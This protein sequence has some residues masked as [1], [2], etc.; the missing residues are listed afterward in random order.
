MV[1][2]VKNFILALGIILL[3]P[4]AALAHVV[5]MPTQVGIGK[6]ETFTLQVPTEKDIPTVGVRLVLPKGLKEVTPIVKP[7]WQ[8]QT[9]KTGQGEDVTIQEISWTAGSIPSGFKDMFVFS[10]QV[11]AEAT[12]LQWKAY[13][14]YQDGSV[15]AWDQAPGGS[16]DA[17]GDKGPYSVTKVVDDLSAESS[18]QDNAALYGAY[19]VA[20]L[21]LTVAIV[22]IVKK[23][24]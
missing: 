11:P 18:K 5:V 12:S 15:V 16:D 23:S 17:E 6:S 7:S 24:R 9:R 10:A 13:Q 3:V 14:T 20:L 21:A 1:K 22:A 8:T 4:A 2:V 19:A